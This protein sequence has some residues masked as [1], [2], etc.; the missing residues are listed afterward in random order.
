M[1]A[2]KQE[3]GG[4]FDAA[5]EGGATHMLVVLDTFDNSD[6]PAYVYPDADPDKKA[7]GYNSREMTRVM[8][9]YDLSMDKDAQLAQRRC[10]N[11]RPATERDN[12]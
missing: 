4:W 7:D 12:A 2:S 5:K 10:W 6:Y 3:I 11:A 8:E 9:I 1:A